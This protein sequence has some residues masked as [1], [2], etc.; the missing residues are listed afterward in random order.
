[1]FFFRWE[2]R[3]LVGLFLFLPF[4]SIS[5]YAVRFS[6]FGVL[7]WHFF[8]IYFG[9]IFIKYFYIDPYFINAKTEPDRCNNNNCNAKDG[10]NTASTK[11]IKNKKRS[12]KSSKYKQQTI[13]YRSSWTWIWQCARKYEIRYSVVTF[14]WFFSLYLLVFFRLWI[15][16]FW[17]WLS[18][19]LL[20]G[21]FGCRCD[22]GNIIP[23]RI[24]QNV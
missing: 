19:R 24:Y 10:E 17:F 15:H 12:Q 21:F 6:F 7:V 3:L 2:F 9:N 8:F 16:L 20:F 23:F 5:F 18:H 13:I 11:Y 1:M 14:E 4:I 22:T